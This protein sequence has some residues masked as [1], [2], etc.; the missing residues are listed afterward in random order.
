MKNPKEKVKT[1]I[2]IDKTLK[3]FAQVYAVQNDMTLG[4]VIEDA[5]RDYL[6]K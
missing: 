2:M 6:E 1:T 4:E 5:L 3:K